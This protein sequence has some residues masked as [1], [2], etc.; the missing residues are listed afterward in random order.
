MPDSGESTG[1]SVSSPVPGSQ[2]RVV[3]SSLSE[4]SR[5]RPSR[6]LHL[7]SSVTSPAC[8]TNVRCGVWGRRTACRTNQVD[9]STALGGMDVNQAVASCRMPCRSCGSASRS[10]WLAASIPETRGGNEYRPKAS[11]MIRWVSSRGL[12]RSMASS[13]SASS[14][15]HACTPDRAGSVT[16]S[17]GGTSAC[18]ARC[19]ADPGWMLI[20]LL[21]PLVADGYRLIETPVRRRRSTVGRTPDRPGH[22]AP[23]TRLRSL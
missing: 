19:A 14:C 3:A 13:F 1:S 21:V 4:T 16:S 7:E 9:S 18:M 15:S 10:R 17:S 20:W 22:W 2:R 5:V 11:C 23:G 8:P 12:M 6:A